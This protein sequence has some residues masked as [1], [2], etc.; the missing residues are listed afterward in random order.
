MIVFG[1]WVQNVGKRT[2]LAMSKQSSK[3]LL[4]VS[5]RE[6]SLHIIAINVYNIGTVCV[7]DITS[8]ATLLANT[9]PVD[10]VTLLRII[11]SSHDWRAPFVVGLEGQAAQLF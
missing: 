11:F 4:K 1:C 8:Q 9:R 6:K 7:N 2:C 10:I 3:Y 5:I